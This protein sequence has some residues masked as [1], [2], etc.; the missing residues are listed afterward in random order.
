MTGPAAAPPPPGTLLLLIRHA[1][2]AT[3][4]RR[5]APLSER[6]E[7]QALRLAERLAALPLTAVVSSHLKRARRTAEVVAD[8]AALEAEVEEGLEEI[9]LG[10]EARWRR[11]RGMLEPDPDDYVSAALNAVRVL[12]RARW[13]GEN[14]EEPIDSL[15][16]FVPWHTGISSVLLKGD[17]HVLLGLNDATH[18]SRDQDM[19]HIVA[20]D[21]V[22]RRS[23]DPGR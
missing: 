12:S 10:E 3:M 23:E 16:A 21:V 19:L 9:H 14:G 17:E 22:S 13:T 6:G 2:Q 15:L 5:D 7:R 11:Y 1:E 4:Q 20:A 8:R 18:L